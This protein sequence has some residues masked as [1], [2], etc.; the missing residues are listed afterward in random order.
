MKYSLSWKNRLGHSLG[1]LEIFRPETNLD[2]VAS[3][4]L[5]PCIALGSESRILFPASSKPCIASIRCLVML[6]TLIKNEN[7]DVIIVHKQHFLSIFLS[8]LWQT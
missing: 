4:G 6:L 7:L 1:S 8:F 2:L 5:D 3:N